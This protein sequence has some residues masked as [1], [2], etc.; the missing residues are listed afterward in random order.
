MEMF[1]KQ[2]KCGTMGKQLSDYLSK[3]FHVKFMGS[4]MV[5]VTLDKILG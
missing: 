3:C 4:V 2:S 1:E 5:C